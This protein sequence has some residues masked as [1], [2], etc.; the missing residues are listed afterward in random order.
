MVPRPSRRF[1]R[2]LKHAHESP[3][4][5]INHLLRSPWLKA[6]DSRGIPVLRMVTPPEHMPSSMMPADQAFGSTLCL[7][8]MGIPSVRLDA[9]GVKAFTLDHVVG[10]RRAIVGASERV[11]Q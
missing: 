4:R 7:G 8:A 1:P 9:L 11:N 6:G 3:L 2:T 10:G 5:M